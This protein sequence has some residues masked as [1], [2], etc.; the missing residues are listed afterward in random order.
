MGAHGRSL[1]LGRLAC[2]A[3]RGARRRSRRRRHARQRAS[4]PPARGSP[5]PDRILPGVVPGRLAQRTARRDRHRPFPRAHDVQ[6][7]PDPRSET[8]RATRRGERRPGQ[9]IHLA[10]RDLVLRRHRGRQA[11]PR[12]RA[13]GRHRGAADPHRGRPGRVPRRGGQLDRLQGAPLWL[14]DHRLDGGHQAD[15]A[16]GDPRLLP[17]VLPPEQ[18]NG[19]GGRG[20]PGSGR[21]REDPPELRTDP[22]RTDSAAGAR[23]RAA[24]ERR[25]TRDGP[26][27]GGAPH[28]LPR[29]ARAE[30]A[31]GRRPG[32]RGP[33]D[34]SCGRPRV[35]A[36]PRPRLPA[37]AR[38]RGGGRLLVLLDRPEP[39][40]VLGDADAGPDAGDPRGGALQAHGAAQG[41]A[42]H[43]GGAGARQEPDR[44]RFR[45]RGRFGP[46]A[47]GASR[48]LRAHRRLRAQGFLHHED[49]RGHGGRSDASGGR[50]VRAGAE[51]R[52]GAVAEAAMTTRAD[53][54]RDAVRAVIV[55]LGVVVPGPA[56]GAPLAHREV[57]PNGIVLLVAERPAVPIVAVRVLTRAGAVYDPDE[58]AGLANLTGAVLTRGTAKRTGPALDSAIEFVGGSLEAG[59]GRDN[60]TVSLTAQKKDLTLGLDLVSEV[61]LSPAFPE[62]EVA[63]KVSEIQAAIKRSEEDPG[64]V[65]ARALARLVFQGHPY[66]VPVEG[67]RESVARLTRDDVVK[68]YREHARPD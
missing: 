46:P 7:H 8:V 53:R 27:G 9:C 61:V 22:A 60:L 52:R 54:C 32:P 15:H 23:R 21:A 10:G 59:A 6:G 30:P 57:L 16:G 19:R 55:L 14:S 38:A 44:V 34:D 68:F 49:P 24:P 29:L 5:Q 3:V 37:P 11:R 26:E 41:R 48:A 56:A 36:L 64:T 43:R 42:R 58:R 65:A 50:L 62:A 20:V 28:R 33:V 67:T 4:C 63:R 40:L 25:A 31:L 45:L 18:C 39:L 47:R 17:D 1:P 51:A 35:A 66:G 12:D 2:G 13:R